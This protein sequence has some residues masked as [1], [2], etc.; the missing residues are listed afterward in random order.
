LLLAALSFC[1]AACLDYQEVLTLS[2]DGSG[3]VDIHLRV[4]KAALNQMSQ[5][6]PGRADDST[7]GGELCSEEEIRAAL[8]AMGSGLELVSYHE[9]DNRDS[10]AYRVHFKFGDYEDFRDLNDVCPDDSAAEES[11]NSFEFSFVEQPNGTWLYSR[12][13]ISAHEQESDDGPGGDPAT[14]LDLPAMDEQADDSDAA[15]AADEPMDVAALSEA[16]KGLGQSLQ[17]LA[18]EADSGDTAMGDLAATMQGLTAGFAA[19]AADAK[20]HTIR[21][22][23]NFPGSVVESNATKVDGLTAVWEYTLDKIETAPKTMTARIA[24]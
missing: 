23:V 3:E 17:G 9:T 21:V 11:G 5:G 12:P 18:G 6:L 13:F 16:L 8:E 10:L 14:G 19:L 2:A 24:R 1:L 20:N 7:G 4:D 15:L 22:A